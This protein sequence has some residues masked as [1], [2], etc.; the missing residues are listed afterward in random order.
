MN[1]PTI[2]PKA[3]LAENDVMAYDIPRICDIYTL[4]LM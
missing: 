2:V 4:G 1:V 3:V